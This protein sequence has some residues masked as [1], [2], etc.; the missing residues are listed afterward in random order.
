MSEVTR[1]EKVKTILGISGNDL[2][3][4][5]DVYLDLA[6]DA[7]I[8]WTFGGDTEMED[9]P[10]EYQE[11]QVWSVVIGWNGRGAEGETSE[12]VEGVTHS[13]DYTLMTNYIHDNC[14]SYVKI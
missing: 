14:P 4:T 3:N 10:S 13:Y 12:S 11:I 7:I 1:L 2:D 9:V 6:K 8:N 5:L